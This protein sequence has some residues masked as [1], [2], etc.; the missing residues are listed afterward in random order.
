MN[1]F[2][3]KGIKATYLYIYYYN[4]EDRYKI[5]GVVNTTAA[6]IAVLPR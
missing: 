4:A 5:L 6:D 3:Q 1:K 2:L